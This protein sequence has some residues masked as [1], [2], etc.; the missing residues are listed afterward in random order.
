MNTRFRLMVFLSVV[1]LVSLA[2]GAG[3]EATEAPAVQPSPPPAEAVAPTGPPASQVELG[4][5]L[6]EE[7]GGFTYQAPLGYDVSA[8]LGIVSMLAEGADPDIGPS[9][10]LIGGPPDPGATAQSLLDQLK[11]AED[12]Q[13]AEPVAVKV[14]GHDGLAA[15]ITIQR[16]GVEI[17][18]RIVTVVTP[19]N[20]L[21]AL[22]GG[23][24]ER[25]EGELE[26]IFEAILSSITFFKPPATPEPIETPTVVPTQTPEATAEDQGDTLHQ[27]AISA[28][29]S[30]EYTDTG[31]NASQATGAPNVT[32]CADDSKAWASEGYDTIEWLEVSYNTPVTPI[33]VNIYETFNPGQIV[34][35]ELLDVNNN[36]H[37]IFTAETQVK[38]CPSVLTIDI[39]S[40]GYQVIAVRITV[41]QT[42][43]LNWDEIDAVELVGY[44]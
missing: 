6:R 8:G 35:V 33:Q 24:K 32:E 34:K 39:P 26:P 18:G 12:T 3:S 7:G 9:I 22:A 5:V 40:A 10:S 27:W 42:Q 25:W 17:V 4:E 30:S 31:W 43:V 2:C 38:A 11:D 28:T 36:Y 20:Q 16:S 1:M 19:E 44:Q 29:A 37:E 15:D 41:D 13:L 23:P 21:I 14:G